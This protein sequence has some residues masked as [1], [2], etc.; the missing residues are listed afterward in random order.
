VECA[1]PL[2]LFSWLEIPEVQFSLF[3]RVTLEK[4]S[5]CKVNLLL[6]ILGKRPDGFHELE[7][8]M[9]PVHLF[10]HLRFT[11]RGNSLRLTCSDPALPVDE[12]NLVHRAATAF[13][14]A[15]GVKNGVE[16]HLE[17]YIPLASGL[18][19]GSGNA[20]TTLFGLNE[21]FGNPLTE[22]H[23]SDLAASVGSDV[24][25]FLQTRPAIATGRGEKIQSLDFFPALAS[26]A[27]LLVHP[28]F[29]MATAWAYKELANFPDAINGRPGRAAKLASLLKARDLG[30][31]AAEFY[32]SL[33]APVLRKHPLLA[34][35]QDFLREHGAIVTLMSGS[36]STT[37]AIFQTRAQACEVERAAQSKFAPCWTAVVDCS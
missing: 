15:S 28:G 5:G 26:T 31:A 16:I 37:F 22:Q 25:F 36:G 32:N 14:K 21:L 7:T 1:S 27:F 34:I 11:R 3:N 29:G 6:N 20:A 24:P 8:L 13:M 30:T 23:L 2:A 4:Q 17:K 9:H 33:E 12:R 10:D 18:G 19:G 35:Y